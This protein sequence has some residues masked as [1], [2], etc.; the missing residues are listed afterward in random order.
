MGGALLNGVIQFLGN[1]IHDLTCILKYYPNSIKMNVAPKK[2]K[3]PAARPQGSPRKTAEF[4]R[5]LNRLCY[6]RLDALMGLSFCFLVSV[7]V[8]TWVAMLQVPFF[9]FRDGSGAAVQ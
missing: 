9:H 8:L 3:N 1:G 6:L 2:R 5:T 7:A 4:L